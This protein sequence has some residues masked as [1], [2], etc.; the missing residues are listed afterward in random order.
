MRK[1]TNAEYVKEYQ[2][3]RDA[4]MLRP[5]KENGA[6]V[7]SAAKDRGMSVQA[8]VM[9]TVLQRIEN[10]KN[11]ERH[12]EMKGE[13]KMKKIINFKNAPDY[14]FSDDERGNTVLVWPDHIDGM[15]IC[16]RCREALESGEI[17]EYRIYGYEIPTT[18][19]AFEE[20]MESINSGDQSA[21][22]WM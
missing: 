14:I 4:I 8:F 15:D 13:Q 21:L 16:F 12:E 2:A 10:E 3:N 7:R 18:A 20:I 22:E 11:P 9:E 19:E 1:K 5:T 17:I 6:L